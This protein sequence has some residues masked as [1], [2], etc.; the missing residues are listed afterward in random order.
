MSHELGALDHPPDFPVEV[1]EDGVS[2]T[3]LQNLCDM[4]ILCQEK[5]ADIL[6]S[7]FRL[8]PFCRVLQISYCKLT[9]IMAFS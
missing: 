3:A 4:T 2:E 1:S 8:D 7:V 5:A 9:E 6:T